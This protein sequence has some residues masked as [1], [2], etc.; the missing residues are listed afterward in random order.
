MPVS[1]NVSWETLI[2]MSEQNDIDSDKI[3]IALPRSGA[4][5]FV[6][7]SSGHDR[8]DGG[9]DDWEPVLAD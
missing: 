3:V 4:A 2:T 5:P 7:E 1:F 9:P 6:P 8:V